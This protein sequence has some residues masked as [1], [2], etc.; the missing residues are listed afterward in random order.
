MLKGAYLQA[1]ACEKQAAG[2]PRHA[3]NLWLII[4]HKLKTQDRVSIWDASSSLGLVCSLC[5][6]T[7]D[8]HEHLFFLCHFSDAVWSQMK[9]R[10]GLDHVS[11]DVY[12]LFDHFEGISRAKSSKIVIAKIVLAAS[13]YFIW[14]ERN[15]RLFKKSK[16]SVK[17]VVDCIA[18]TVRLKLLSCRFRRSKDG[19]HYARLW[20]L[21][22]TIFRCTTI[23][24]YSTRSS[25]SGEE[26]SQEFYNNS[27]IISGERIRFNP[28][29]QIVNDHEN[30][31]IPL[32]IREWSYE[33]DGPYVK[34]LA[35]LNCILRHFVFLR[36]LD[37]YGFVV[38]LLLGLREMDRRF[39][40]SR[41]K[42][43]GAITFNGDVNEMQGYLFVDLA[44]KIKNIDGEVLKKDAPR[45]A[46][47]GVRID[48]DNVVASPSL[49]QVVSPVKLVSFAEQVC[50]TPM[51]GYQMETDDPPLK[52]VSIDEINSSDYGTNQ[53]S[54]VDQHNGSTANKNTT[55]V[56][57]VHIGDVYGSP[58]LKEADPN[59]K[60]FANVVE[61]ANGAA[62]NDNTKKKINI[63]TII[64]EDK[65]EN[66]DFVLPIESIQIVKNKF[67]Y[68]LVGFFV[69]KGIAFPLVQ[70]YVSRAWKEFGFQ[71]IMRD[72]DGFFYFKFESIKGMEQVLEQ[73]PWL[74]QN[75]PL[76]LNKWSV[77]MSLSKDDV[78]K[79]R[80]GYVRAL[81]EISADK[82]LKQKVVM[83]VPIED[84]AGHT[85]ERI[86][87]E[88]EWKL[89]LCLECHVFGHDSNSCPKKAHDAVKP[90]S[91]S[92]L[93]MKQKDGFT[94]VTHKKKKT[95]NQV[96]VQPKQFSGLKL[97]K[98]TSTMVWNK[99]RLNPEELKKNL[100]S[101]LVENAE[102]EWGD[103]QIWGNAKHVVSTVNESDSEEVNENINLEEPPGQAMSHA[104]KGNS[105]P[106][107]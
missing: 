34:D 55:D 78:K 83:A 82:A 91:N 106:H 15:W 64:S 49:E 4:K 56:L 104:N 52:S 32:R 66:S 41:I 6:S 97:N 85:L 10:A 9:L 45:M 16:R 60:A 73:G 107:G 40:N 36:G 48:K 65:V 69:G 70:I 19:L 42:A 103:D 54:A 86:K 62:K 2:I 21:P 14:Q 1:S 68:S 43:N 76:I 25:K 46:V 75:S 35:Y 58:M 51:K 90:S 30:V 84:G 26:R 72:D 5:E 13:A 88:Y 63:H 44:K 94:T 3:F 96:N 92:G 29:R 102:V 18:S 37:D 95:K 100:F 27:G 28:F 101:Q 50:I 79:G 71:K 17:Q 98:P 87:L 99:K 53:L 39:A 81:I 8:S 80:M 93:E 61:G 38:L 33:I 31:F 105:V 20:D 11:H 47:R 57:K 23:T 89:P 7:P 22:D 67:A 74:I 77:N 24:N 12:A 59:V